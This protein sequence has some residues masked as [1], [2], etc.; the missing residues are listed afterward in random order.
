MK[1]IVLITLIMTMGLLLF[2]CAKKESSSGPILSEE[3]SE[4]SSEDVSDENSE[5]VLV[6]GTQEEDAGTNATDS[7]ATVTLLADVWN[8]YG[9]A[10]KF[11]AMGGDYTTMVDGIPGAFDVS[12]AENTS[13]LFH[14]SQ[15]LLDQVDEGA[16]LLHGMNLNTFT[17]VALHLTDAS[18]KDAFVTSLKDEIMAT[19]WMCGFP[20]TLV[21]YTV[22]DEYV[23]YAFGGMDFIETFKDKVSEVY[24]DRAVL[25][26]EESLA[27]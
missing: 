6:E 11:P 18:G 10:D 5:D 17:G 15:D 12:S 16:S 1:K 2:G 14:M 25:A 8:A 19:E 3:N 13:N 24:G 9:E 23:V 22:D 26:V 7:S 27:F 4:M 21:I 20:D